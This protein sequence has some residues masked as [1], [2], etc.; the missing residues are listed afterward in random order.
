[1]ANFSKNGVVYGRIVKSE[2]GTFI[3]FHVPTKG[4][5]NEGENCYIGE[6]TTKKQAEQELHKYME[7]LWECRK[8]LKKEIEKRNNP[9]KRKFLGIF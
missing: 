8:K 4:Y 5:F 3:A 1:M 6:Y 7:D 2:H 9:P